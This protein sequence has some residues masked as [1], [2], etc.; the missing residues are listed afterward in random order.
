M[1]PGRIKQHRPPNVVVVPEANRQRTRYFHTGSKAW[2]SIR[3]VQLAKFPMCEDC[4]AAGQLTVAREVDH[5]T[6]DTSA[7]RIGVD[8]SSLCKPCH[9]ARTRGRQLG[10]RPHVKGCDANGNPLDPEHEWNRA[11]NREEPAIHGTP[12]QLYA[13]GRDSEMVKK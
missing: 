5:N 6:G 2:R 1:M 13:R 9:S 10:P 7:N 3:A 12:T 4:Q 11:K 8:L